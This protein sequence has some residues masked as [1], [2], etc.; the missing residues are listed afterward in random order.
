MVAMTVIGTGAH[1][2]S[3]AKLQWP[4]QM[5]VMMQAADGSLESGDSQSRAAAIVTF[6]VDVSAAF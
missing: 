2:D 6:V 4:E 3:H 1:A 5:R